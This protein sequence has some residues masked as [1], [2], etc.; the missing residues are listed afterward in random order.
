MKKFFKTLAI[1]LCL[2]M[3]T[4]SV[5]PIVGT[6]TVQAATKAKT[7]IKLNCTKKTIYE[8]DTFKLKITGTKKKVKWSSSNKKVATVSS[9]GVVKGIDGGANQRS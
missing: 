5:V 8:G 1:I 6:E 3:F 4:P 2:S 7:K 9:K